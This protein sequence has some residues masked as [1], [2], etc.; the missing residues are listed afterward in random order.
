MD[1][2]R[3]A[4]GFERHTSYGRITPCSAPLSYRGEKDFHPGNMPLDHADRFLQLRLVHFG[5]TTT[6]E[7]VQRRNSASLTS[8]RRV[9][10]GPRDG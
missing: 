5:R 9:P 2:D 8:L 10:E 4:E 7:V 1:S 6:C 3:V